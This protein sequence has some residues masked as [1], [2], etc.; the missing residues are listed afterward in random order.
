VTL[1]I[2]LPAWVEAMADPGRPYATD[3]E[4]VRFAIA[5]ARENVQ[6]R[7][8][9]PRPCTAPPAGRSTTAE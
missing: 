1:R 3:P 8:G 7:T 5:L 9:G 4:R 2:D 6:R